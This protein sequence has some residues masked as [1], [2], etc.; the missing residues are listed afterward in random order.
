MHLVRWFKVIKLASS[1]AKQ[2]SDHHIPKSKSSRS[3]RDAEST[4]ADILDAAEE[5]FAKHGLQGARMDA[6]AAKTGV[7]KAMIY[8]YFNSK[9]D[10]YKTVLKRCF[11]DF[12][13]AWEE[14]KLETLPPNVALEQFVRRAIEVQSKSPNICHI[15]FHEAIQNQ[16]K[17]YRELDARLFYDVLTQILQRGIADGIFRPLDA[18]HCAIN[19]VGTCVFYFMAYENIRHV[20]GGEPMLSPA[21]IEKHAQEAVD[22][23]L[24]GVKVS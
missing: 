19:I 20:W 3:V 15:L 21:A 16:G 17:Y 10:V 13:C 11:Q 2:S 4:R 6:I 22:L 9:E 8:Y 1:S 7:T 18:D 14:Q 24:A 12:A 23:V 5:E